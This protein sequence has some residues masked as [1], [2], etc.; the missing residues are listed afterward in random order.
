M[1][2]P[3]APSSDFLRPESSTDAGLL[4]TQTRETGPP[5][6]FLNRGGDA[7]AEEDTLGPSL[8]AGGR[9][10]APSYRVPLRRLGA[11]V[12]RSRVLPW[13]GCVPAPAGPPPSSPRKPA[14][15]VTSGRTR[16]DA[17][18]DPSCP[19][20]CSY[21]SPAVAAVCLARLTVPWRVSGGT[22][23]STARAPRLRRESPAAGLSSGPGLGP[24]RDPGCPSLW[25]RRRPDSLWIA[26]LWARKRF[27]S[28]S[29]S[30]R[31]TKSLFFRVSKSKRA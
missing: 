17:L 3:G 5:D 18:T 10:P 22:A 15:P 26:S 13:P 21:T 20:P 31:V 27:R 8:T 24:A 23:G 30:L 1:S 2:P 9:G 29:F 25:A 4:G 19:G 7:A 12:T 28:F 6:S 14:A 16:F 11:P